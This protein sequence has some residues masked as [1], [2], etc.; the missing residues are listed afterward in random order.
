MSEQDFPQGRQEAA[1]GFIHDPKSVIA[2]YFLHVERPTS[3]DMSAVAGLISGPWREYERTA[4]ALNICIDLAIRIPN[5][6]TVIAGM[7]DI[8]HEAIPPHW[9]D[10]EDTR[11]I[12]SSVGDMEGSILR[13][14][15]R[16]VIRGPA[17][18]GLPERLAEVEQLVSALQE[19]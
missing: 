13:S 18:P 11:A 5:A 16:F 7:F 10:P 17:F 8:D 14:Q 9:Q 15:Q 19:Q 6:T 3:K 2:N 12:L 1:S 4:D